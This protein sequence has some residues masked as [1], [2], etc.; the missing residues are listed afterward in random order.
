R[1]ID[2]CDAL[3]TDY[4]EEVL[5]E[6]SAYRGRQRIPIDIDVEN[7]LNDQPALIRRIDLEKV[8]AIGRREPRVGQRFADKVAAIFQGGSVHTLLPNTTLAASPLLRST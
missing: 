7:E 3:A 6:G 5:G 8:D 4:R 2:E 1:D